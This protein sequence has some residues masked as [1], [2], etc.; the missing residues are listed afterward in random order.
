[1]PEDGMY[2]DRDRESALSIARLYCMELLGKKRP[3]PFDR[4]Y[5]IAS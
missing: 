5:V 1:V 3:Y 2:L 4:R